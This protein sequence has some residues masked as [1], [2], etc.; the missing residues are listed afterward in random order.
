MEYPAQ[1]TSQNSYDDRISIKFLKPS[2]K[3]LLR[4]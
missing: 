2:L 4:S 3:I 1:K